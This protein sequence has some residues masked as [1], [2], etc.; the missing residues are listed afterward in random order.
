MLF[1][2]DQVFLA[3]FSTTYSIVLS[4]EVL[5]HISIKVA[6][7]SFQELK[8]FVYHLSNCMDYGL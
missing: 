3:I 2:F 4:A 7:L 5:T 8:E 6:F 1:I